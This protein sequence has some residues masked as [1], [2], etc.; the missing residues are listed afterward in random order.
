MRFRYSGWLK[1]QRSRTPTSGLSRSAIAKP[2]RMR[3][4]RSSAGRVRSI[5]CAGPRSFVSC[6]LASDGTGTTAGVGRASGGREAAAAWAGAATA[7]GARAT[8]TVAGC[9]TGAETAG[10][11]AGNDSSSL[12]DFGSDSLGIC[13]HA[14]ASTHIAVAASSLLGFSVNGLAFPSARAAMVPMLCVGVKEV[15]DSEGLFSLA[16]DR[17]PRVG[18]T[19]DGANGVSLQRFFDP[20][21]S[22][23]ILPLTQRGEYSS[24]IADAF[25]QILVRGF[26]DRGPR[27]AQKWVGRLFA[28][29]RRGQGRQVVAP[30]LSVAHLALEQRGI[31]R[32]DGLGEADVRQ[33]VLVAAVDQRVLGQ[34]RELLER[35][36]ELLGR[37][38]EYAPASAGEQRIATEQHV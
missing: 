3:S 32:L 19:R 11:T 35:R 4:Q 24:W 18:I 28:S 9:T 6:G 17:E 16:I 7:A 21:R 36:V 34:R 15:G 27:H 37:A 5:V 23:L 1:Y 12:G 38:F 22:E 14:A 8:P 33:G 20:T 29:Y 2:L 25:A 10:A 30:C 26:D 31:I 13:E